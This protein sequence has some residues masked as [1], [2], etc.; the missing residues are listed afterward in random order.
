MSSPPRYDAFAITAP[1]LEHVAAGELRALGIEGAR[2]GTGGVSF[3]ALPRELYTANLHFRTASRVVV[4]LGSFTATAFYELERRAGK[5]P[6]ETLLPP[7]LGVALSVTC[8]KSRLY[9]SDAVAERVAAAITA[10]V[11]GVR[12]VDEADDEAAE[13]PQLVLVRLFHDRCTVSVDSSGA[14]LHMRGY[15][16]A[17]AKAP[18]RETLAA[19]ALLASG[20][21]GTAPLLD[22]MC[23]S[24]TIP[25]EGALLARRIAPGL[26]RGFAFER[27]PAFE[28]AVWREVVGEA[29]SR[30]LPAAPVPI[31][32]SDRD[33]G[34]IEAALG[35]AER[36]GVSGDVELVQ[37]PLSAIAPPEGPGWLVSNPPYGVRVGDRDR[38][39]NL[40]AQL[41]KVARAK[42]PEWRV[43][44][45][46]ADAALERQTKLDLRS[47]LATSNGG[48]RVRLMLGSV[49]SEA[50]ASDR[51]H[52][53]GSTDQAD[54]GVRV[55]DS[56]GRIDGSPP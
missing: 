53:A 56:A 38:L 46:S 2:A 43:A 21:S 25:I 50:T 23:G 11:R 39:R 3:R 35:N 19:A 14:L 45:V 28:R 5:L 8:R 51:G 41:G 30:I 24:G 18:V 26:H 15:R 42:C 22:P 44:L 33:A 52:P 29:E 54:Q 31:Q 48:I 17:V 34:A 13:P 9:H 1:G 7:N 27:W 47:A 12:I 55:V 40:Y 16:Q 20:W 6:W 37:R 36:A 4:R 49:P 32:G 10:R